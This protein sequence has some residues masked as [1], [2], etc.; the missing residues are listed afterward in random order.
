MKM[1]YNILVTV[2][3]SLVFAACEKDT[4]GDPVMNEVLKGLSAYNV[5][6]VGEGTVVVSDGK[7]IQVANKP[8]S[9][10][11]RLSSLLGGDVNVTASIDTSKLLVQAFDSLYKTKSPILG[12]GVFQVLQGGKY[13]IPAGKYQSADSVQVAA[14]N[15]SGYAPGSYRFV[16]PVRMQSSP[17]GGLASSLLFVKYNVTVANA[18]IMTASTGKGNI[19]QTVF[20]SF[21]QTATPMVLVALDKVV[22]SD[23]K[24]AVEGVSTTALVDAY[25]AKFNTSYK[26]FPAGAF[27]F[28]ADSLTIKANMNITAPATSVIFRPDPAKFPSGSTYL[29]ALRLKDKQQQG[30][31]PTEMLNSTNVLFAII[32]SL[33]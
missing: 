12:S 24:F 26:P 6:P 7:L 23:M 8:A 19:V 4:V 11:P 30:M 9:F 10:F 28:S 27:S 13:T 5:V 14:G 21:P 29:L 1:Y 17:G 15:V 32:T 20:Q 2:L 22:S 3:I 31:T 18:F 16:V 25:N 33:P